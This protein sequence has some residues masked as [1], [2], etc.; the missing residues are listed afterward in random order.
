IQ[1]ITAA[2]T[3]NLSRTDVYSIIQ[4]SDGEPLP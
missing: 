3:V 4:S 2:Q 1:E